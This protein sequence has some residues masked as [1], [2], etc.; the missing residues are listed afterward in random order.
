MKT[1]ITTPGHSLAGLAWVGALL[2]MAG[3]ADAQ[4][5]FVADYNTQDI[6]EITPGGSQSVFASG[7]NY[8]GGIAFNSMG[9]LFV[10]NTAQNA[11]PAQGSITEIAPNGTQSTF[12]SGID[13]QVVVFNS[14]G[15]LFEAD[16][17][18]GNIYEY[19]PGGVR[20]TF[21]SGFTTPIGLV[22]DSTGNLF[23]GSGYGN[24]N[25]IITKITP[26]GMQSTFASG[27][28]FPGGFAFNSAGDLFACD[29]GGS[30]YEFT[31]GGVRS[32]FASVAGP[33]SLAFNNAGNLFVSTHTGP[34]I[35]IT[36]G[37]T[38]ST[39]MSETGITVGLAFQP[40]PE[41]STVALIGLGVGAL[42]IR[43]RK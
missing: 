9:D 30:I 28:N 17:R 24:G 18:S 22:F 14:T 15:D 31:P 12:V 36:P 3:S 7:L 20:S 8:P 1:K 32:T 29:S 5:L 37:G 42:I 41:P 2:L 27:L 25:G 39:F 11:I 4:N 34:I 23:V 16:Y 21:A 6:Y 19:T 40:V 38:E 33:D 10:A 13:P 35:E 43:R 26:G